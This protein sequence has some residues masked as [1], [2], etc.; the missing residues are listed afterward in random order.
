M[1]IVISISPTGEVRFFE[2]G[3]GEVEEFLDNEV[4]KGNI[5]AIVENGEVKELASGKKIEFNIERSE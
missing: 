1:E 3:E 2:V 5:I 4:S